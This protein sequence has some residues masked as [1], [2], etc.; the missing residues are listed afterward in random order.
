M[1]T[2]MMTRADYAARV[3]DGEKRREAMRL[4]E[5]MRAAEKACSEAET[6][7]GDALDAKYKPIYQQA[8]AE[9]EAAHNK[10]VA[11]IN[12][13]RNAEAA[14]SP[15]LQ[16]LEAATK[17]WQDFPC[18]DFNRDDDDE[19]VLC[20]LSGLPIFD[21]DCVMEDPTTG[22]KVLKA[23]LGVPLDD[24]NDGVFALSEPEDGAKAAA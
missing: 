12:A 21:G 9:A 16:Q 20:A 5:V 13:Q 11:E 10:R 17:A 8:R 19:P 24:D 23:C 22:E 1:T 14:D 3:P 6:A 4:F 7:A 18:E 2:A 15:Q